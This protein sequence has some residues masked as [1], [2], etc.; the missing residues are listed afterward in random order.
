MKR[1]ICTIKIGIMVVKPLHTLPSGV[2]LGLDLLLFET[3]VDQ[4]FEK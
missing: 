3:K 4:I 1:Q 2:N